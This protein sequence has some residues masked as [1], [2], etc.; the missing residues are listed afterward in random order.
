MNATL[1]GFLDYQRATLAWKCAGLDAA[2][3]KVTVAPACWRLHSDRAAKD[4]RTEAA[5]ADVFLGLNRRARAQAEIGAAE[6][7]DARAAG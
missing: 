6:D 2:G 7:R 3:L 1:L 4:E 5:A